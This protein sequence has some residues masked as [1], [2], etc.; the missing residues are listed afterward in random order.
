MEEAMDDQGQ[1]SVPKKDRAPRMN[2]KADG[3]RVVAAVALFQRITG[4]AMESYHFWEDF[5]AWAADQPELAPWKANGKCW[6]VRHQASL[7]RHSPEGR[8][9]AVES[10]RVLA[11]IKK[12]YGN[13]RVGDA[14]ALLEQQGCGKKDHF[15]QQLHAEDSWSIQVLDGIATLLGMSRVD[16]LGP[17]PT[18][19]EIEKCTPTVRVT[20]QAEAALEAAV[21]PIAVA[22]APASEPPP[23]EDDSDASTIFRPGAGWDDAQPAQGKLPGIASIPPA[24]APEDEASLPPDD[25]PMAEIFVPAN[26]ASPRD[27][28][29]R[30]Y[31]SEGEDGN[32]RVH[33]KDGTSISR[34]EVDE[35]ARLRRLLEALEGIDDHCI[36]MDGI[37][38]RLLITAARGQDALTAFRER[39]RP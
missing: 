38:M 24:E 26:A 15:S 25:D 37:A 29:P 10:E 30:P 21:A 35:L 34:A 8:R 17:E 14:Y 28:A 22:A 20:F 31:L 36:G 4:R 9:Q 12:K 13:G 23:A 2:I 7:F 3:M 27:P 6:S 18:P 33:F 11:L 32:V 39:R 5:A 16:M 19:E 1:P